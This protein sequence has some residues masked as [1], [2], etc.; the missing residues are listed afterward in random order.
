MPEWCK[1]EVWRG[2]R[3][4]CVSW[5]RV[6][7]SWGRLSWERL[8][9]SGG[10]LGE[11]LSHAKPSFGHLEAS[12]AIRVCRRL[13]AQQ[14]NHDADL[15]ATAAVEAK[16]MQAMERS[17]RRRPGASSPANSSHGSNDSLCRSESV[18]VSVSVSSSADMRHALSNGSHQIYVFE[19]VYISTWAGRRYCERV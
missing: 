8:G 1:T 11:S 3:S 7:A 17:P 4:K 18:S 9:L 12:S 2:F 16:A 6:G 14:T 13:P 15:L 19:I 10:D 5:G